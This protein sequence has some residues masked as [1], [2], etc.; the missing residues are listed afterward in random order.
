MLSSIP[1]QSSLSK[2][3][4]PYLSP[5]EILDP[6]FRG[7]NALPLAVPKAPMTTSSAAL[8]NH[9]RPLPPFKADKSRKLV[10]I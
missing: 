4:R 2:K 7:K 3:Q 10:Q 8:K 9:M 5:V 6:T 1:S